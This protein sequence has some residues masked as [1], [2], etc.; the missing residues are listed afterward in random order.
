MSEGKKAILIVEDTRITALVYK[1]LLAKAFPDKEIIV[2]T[3]LEEAQ[4]ELSNPTYR[5][6]AAVIDDAFG[7]EIECESPGIELVKHLRE[8]HFYKGSDTIIIYNSADVTEQ[9][10]ETVL[11]YGGN[12][13]CMEKNRDTAMKIIGYIT[14]KSEK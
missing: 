9:M 14:E 7:C 10:K 2:A 12:T 13:T 11:S 1:N 8:E 6:V 3:T 4:Q 5:F